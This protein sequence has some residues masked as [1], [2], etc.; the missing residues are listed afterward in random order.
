MTLKA[1][2]RA[3][4][5]FLRLE[6][7]S[8]ILLMV[9]AF[10]AMILA[11]S[12]LASLYQGLLGTY[13]EVRV[14]SLGIEKPLLLWINDGLM[15]VFFLLV[16][17]E[18]K[19]EI[20]EGQLSNISQIALPGVAATGGLVVPALI[21]VALNR[22][23][24]IA[25]NGWAIPAATDIAFALGILFLLGDRV[26]T[27]LKL[28]LMTIAI[29]DDLTAI[30]IIAVFYSGDL[31]LLS[32]GLATGA[33]VVL[34]GMNLLGVKRLAAY[35]IV[36]VLLW[37]FVLKSGVH[38][39]LA[40]VALAFAIP[41]QPRIAG[42][43]H[44]SPLHH[45]EHALHPYVAFGILP[46]FAFANAGVSLAGV[47]LSTLFRSVP[48]GIALG[49]II[50]KPVG[51]F[52]ASWLSVKAGI[53][54][55]PERMSW[56]ELYGVATLCGVGFTMSLFIGSLA[57]EHGGPDYATLDRLGILT[58][59]L[60]SAVWGYLILRSAIGRGAAEA[61]EYEVDLGTA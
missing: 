10:L 1:P 5:N 14:G 44:H 11:N 43:E 19:R 13:A 45:V 16:G 2:A 17:L 24:P 3:I 50:G 55:L 7:A 53:A 59:S 42:E 18:V 9:A 33:L 29:F 60:V 49:L 51:V 39:T 34:A 26:P 21:Y 57:F 22:G 28:L 15:A 30:V 23:D 38:A 31:S 32:L 47:S 56:R 8:G 36:G 48:L 20:R 58:G 52:G 41:W 4:R 46:L 40:G 37:I 35:A 25:L 54:K 61:V 27:S 6:S 12:P